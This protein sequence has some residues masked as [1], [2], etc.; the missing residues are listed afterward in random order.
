MLTHVY[1]WHVEVHNVVSTLAPSALGCKLHGHYI[2]WSVDGALLPGALAHPPNEE[3]VH[4]ALF[5]VP[6]VEWN[7]LPHFQVGSCGHRPKIRT[8]SRSQLT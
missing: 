7:R 6:P 3:D 2:A 5:K 8:M 1:V 4:A